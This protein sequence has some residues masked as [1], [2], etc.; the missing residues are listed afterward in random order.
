MKKAFLAL[1]LFVSISGYTQ[2][3]R[4]D[5]NLVN[6]SEASFIWNEYNPEILDST[7]FI[8]SD[9]GNS[10]PFSVQPLSF[11]DTITKNKT[12]LF[13]WEDLNHKDR[14]GQSEFT[15]QLLFH[16][17]NEIP[18]QSEDKFNIA[19][20]DRKGGNDVGRSIHTLLSDSF[21]N[22]RIQLADKVI[23]FSHKYDFF[24]NQVN[25]E[26]Y[27][28]MEE[29]MELLKKEPADRMRILV[30]ITAGSN[31][32]NYGGK[33]NF[34]VTKSIEMKIPVYL[35]K[36]PIPHC[37]HCSNINQI[38]EASFGRQIENLDVEVAKN[39]LLECYQ[40]MAERHYGQD[41]CVSFS[42]DF[43]R[44]GKPHTLQ[45]SVSGKEYSISFTSPSFS[46][47][48][49]MKE[50]ILWSVVICVGLLLIIAFAVFFV[51]RSIKKRQ[52]K[53][54]D[55]EAKQLEIKQEADANR[56]TLENYRQQSEE[57]E[58]IAKEQEQK[59]YFTQLMQTKNL[60][61][62]LQY[63]V[64]GSNKNYTIHKPE[65]TIGRDEDNDLML[66]SDSVSRHHAKIIFNGSCFEIQ[67]LESTNKVIV[68]GSFVQRSTLSTGDIIGLGEIILYFYN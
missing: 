50:H 8:L 27:L 46:L 40:N 9:N 68:N 20:F 38:S 1:L 64:S 4:G 65:T 25:S 11:S 10:I 63:S 66:L 37:E 21:T 16:F 57:K 43:P 60:L 58:R 56:K 67:D 30:V 5:F 7:Q 29:G 48:I 49:W 61:P 47:A 26:L 15:K 35:V 17:L 19:I 13:L 6:F 18:T 24:S 41:Y 22:E 32:N 55:I 45:W 23:N 28:A 14:K 33:G 53:L 59:K 42:L 51:F 52:Q 31:Q 36:Y 62:R 3:I 12:I 54:R 34:D 44:D 39:L 2:T